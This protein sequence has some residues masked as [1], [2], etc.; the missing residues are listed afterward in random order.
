MKF[1]SLLLALPLT[2]QAF[3]WEDHYTFEDIVPPAGIDP[4]VGGMDITADGHLVAAFHRGEVMIYND[5]TKIWS[6]F[7]TGLHEPLGLMV[8]DEGTVLIV[9]RSEVTRLHDENKDGVADFY[10]TVCDDWGMTGNYHEFAFGIVKD[11]KKNIYIALGTAS[12]GSGAREEV[13]G[14]WNDAGGLTHEK[15]LYGGDHGD[16]GGIR[17]KNKI[18]RM[19]ARVPS[20][21]CVV[22]ITPGSRKAEV[23][24]TGF[25]TPN[26]L[27]MDEQDHLW[28]CDNQ[29]DWLGASKM[30]RV[31]P[32]A[33]HGHPGSL[34]WAPKP[35]KVTPSIIDPKTL[36]GMRT[37]SALLTPQ[38]DCGNSLTQI[39]PV[40]GNKTFPPADLPGNLLIGEMNSARFVRYIPD[41]VNGTPQGTATHFL[42]TKSL[43]NGNN[44]MVYSKDGKTMLIGKTH[45]S[46][47][48]NAGIKKVTYKNKPYL[49]AGQIKLTPKGFAFKF[50]EKLKAL[51]AMPKIGSYKLAYHKNY[52]SPQIDKRDE[53]VDSIEIKDDVL[54]VVLK[55]KPEADRIYDIL[56]PKELTGATGAAPSSTRYWYTA[57]AVYK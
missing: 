36:D 34:L 38:G 2:A 23:Y 8:E 24:A 5:A 54:I 19:Y 11:S 28:V 41:T 49:L 56:L 12:N 15:F 4:Q 50:N 47:A 30:F 39:L 48:G 7:A 25:R 29:G 53:A 3:T 22:K 42:N 26:G 6:E 14:E 40:P 46:W 10:E 13:R 51:D 57:H 37:R 33:F 1:L 31:K 44:R 17:G 35:P 20:R 18:P 52:G 32:N 45:L 55:T 21:G 27:H 43:R 9:Q 16:W